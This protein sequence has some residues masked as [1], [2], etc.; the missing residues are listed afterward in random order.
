MRQ[1]ER[2]LNKKMSLAEQKREQLRAELVSTRWSLSKS[3]IV[4]ANEGR[5]LSGHVKG[6]GST[7]EDNDS[8]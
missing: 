5:A 7:I 4:G 8:E 1:L 3:H 2:T 6:E